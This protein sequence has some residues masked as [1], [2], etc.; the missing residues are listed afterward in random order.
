[1]YIHITDPSNILIVDGY[2]IYHES[3]AYRITI[4]IN[5][6]R[7]SS[8]RGYIV[9]LPERD[10]SVARAQYRSKD[11][12]S[13]SVAFDYFL[14]YAPNVVRYFQSTFDSMHQFSRHFFHLLKV[15]ML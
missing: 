5:Y 12:L 3:E 14:D 2:N 10:R 7:L 13:V 1:M 9:S 6:I 4:A 8:Q 15:P 11:L